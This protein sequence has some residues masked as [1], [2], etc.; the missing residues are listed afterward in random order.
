MDNDPL[1]LVGSTI[2]GKYLIE[3]VV[4]EGGFAVVYRATHTV[5]KRT[6]AVKVFK[7]LGD[8]SQ[9]R[10]QKLLEDFIREGALLAELS[11]RSTAIV[12]A[13]DVGTVALPQGDEVPFMVLEWLDGETLEHMLTRENLRELPLRSLEEAVRLLTPVAEA[14]ALAHQK[15]IAHRDVKPGNVFVLGDA[16]G[17]CTVKL[18]DF[19]IAKVV[20]DAQKDAG[21]FRKTVGLPSSFT[22]LYGAPEQFDRNLGFSGPWTDVYALTLVL[23]ELMLGREVMEGENMLQLAVAATDERRRPTPQALGFLVSNEVQA[24]F[25]RAVAVRPETRYATAGDMWT[26]LCGALQ[27]GPSSTFAQGAPLSISGSL[28]SCAGMVSSVSVTTNP[29]GAMPSQPLARS[30]MSSSSPRTSAVLGPMSTG[31]MPMVPPSGSFPGS[32]TG[33]ALTPV[34]A[35]A[36]TSTPTP[37]RGGVLAVALVGAV[38]LAGLAGLLVLRGRLS[39]QGK[40]AR[41]TPSAS[42]PASAS[43]PAPAPV[44][45]P[46]GMLKIEGGEF[47]M[48]TDD[49]KAKEDERPAHPVKLSAYCLDELE[50]TLGE[51]RA[52]SDRGKCKRAEP[53]NEWEGITPRQRKIYDPICT[54]GD[55]PAKASHPINCVDWRMAETFCEEI[56]GGRLPTEAE[57]EFAARG[58]DGRIFPWGDLP[59]APGLINA[60]GAECVAWGRKNYDPE[61]PLTTMYK[62]SDGF[63]TTAPVG[64]F[65]KGKTSHGMQDMV[66]NVWEWVADFHAPYGDPG[67]KLVDPKGPSNGEEKVIRGGAWNGADPAWLRPTYRYFAPALMRSHGIGFRCAK[68]F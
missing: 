51:Y 17:A 22:P 59:P 11:E 5:W 24:V 4:G 57:W 68:P 46:S 52:C 60:C 27:M 35:S 33:P 30:A 58:S 32:T 56:R 8:V 9:E 47:Y 31:T 63:P 19:G 26:A 3:S 66:G 1:S 7:V 34:A 18:L 6:V 45:C 28:P 16:R 42:P 37:R 25:A 38:A 29:S 21:S 13:R 67:K 10:R 49:K 54:A 23:L 65:P 12:Q 50:V 61:A 39:S 2:S 40:D 36:P 14:L 48:G 41:E 64:S 53:Q 43:A 55:F 44:T 62:T 20:Q 15:G